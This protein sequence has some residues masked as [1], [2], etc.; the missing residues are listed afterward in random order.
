[1]IQ[2]SICTLYERLSSSLA[3]RPSCLRTMRVL[4][5]VRSDQKA[6]QP[7]ADAAADRSW[8]RSRAERQFSPSF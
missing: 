4:D 1:M 2:D 5:P 7:S 8:G 6:G 3:Q